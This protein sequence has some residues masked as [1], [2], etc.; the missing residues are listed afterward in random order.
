MEREPLPLKLKLRVAAS[1]D[2]PAASEVLVSFPNEWE[3]IYQM[4]REDTPLY[5][6]A[7]P[8]SQ[9]SPRHDHFYRLTPEINL[10]LTTY[11]LYKFF[12]P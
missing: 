8:P 1:I 11:R 3:L 10:E 4:R 7:M 9:E 2:Y 5:I 6:A 12:Q